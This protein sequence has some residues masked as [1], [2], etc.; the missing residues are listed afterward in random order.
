MINSESAN[1]IVDQYVKWLR[2]NITSKQ[3]EGV[4]ELSTPFL[5][6]SSD[7]MQIYIS[8][9]NERLRVSDDGDTI[10]NLRASGI[11]LNGRIRERVVKTV[12]FPSSSML[13]TF[14]VSGFCSKLHSPSLNTFRLPIT[15]TFTPLMLKTP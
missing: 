13:M 4:L 3:M 8:R 11:E 6:N 15:S 7:H 5:D 10:R 9:S 1:E 12:L 2:G 14:T